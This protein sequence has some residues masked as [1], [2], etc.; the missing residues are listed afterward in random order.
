M[1][2]SEAFEV[3]KG[4]FTQLAGAAD[5]YARSAIAQLRRDMVAVAANQAWPVG[6]IYISTVSTNP[7]TLLGVGTWTAFGTGR[8]LI[9]INS[10]DVDFDTVEETGGAKTHTLTEA[11]LAAH[12]H[13]IDHN[14]ASFNSGDDGGHVHTLKYPGGFADPGAGGHFFAVRQVDAGSSVNGTDT[15]PDHNH[16]VDVPNYT[17]DSGSAGSGTAVTHLPPYIVTYMWKRTA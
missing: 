5:H 13:A 7:A 12:D 9:G 10:G 11:N 16:T 6:S 14:H 2:V 4:G 8:T 1:P 15:E 17:G 3:A